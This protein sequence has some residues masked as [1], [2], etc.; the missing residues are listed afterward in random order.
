MGLSSMPIM[1]EAELRRLPKRFQEREAML[2]RVKE[3]AARQ[4]NPAQPR[5]KLD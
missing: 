1:S 3:Q 5:I 2:A 4:L